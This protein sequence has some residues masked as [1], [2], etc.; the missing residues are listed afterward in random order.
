MNP[1]VP[2]TPLTRVPGPDHTLKF[3]S[4][5]G[6]LISIGPGSP[7]PAIV[8]LVVVPFAKTRIPALNTRTRQKHAEIARFMVAPLAASEHCGAVDQVYAA[9]SSIV[10]KDWSRAFGVGSSSTAKAAHCR[11]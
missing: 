10:L 2:S 3:S 8:I 9:N 5:F 4:I 1:S 11:P 6:S 7:A